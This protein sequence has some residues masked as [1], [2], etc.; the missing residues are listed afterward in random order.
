MIFLAFNWSR[1][2]GFLLYHFHNVSEYWHIK[3]CAVIRCLDGARRPKG[4]HKILCIIVS[5]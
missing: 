3:N 2:M 4:T 1:L 5:I